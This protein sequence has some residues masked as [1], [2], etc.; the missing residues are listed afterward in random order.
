VRLQFG[1]NE[2]NYKCPSET[3]FTL[4]QFPLSTAQQEAN[5]YRPLRNSAREETA[6]YIT[7]SLQKLFILFFLPFIPP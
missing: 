7:A 1:L 5:P 6:G 4:A 2:E 3:A